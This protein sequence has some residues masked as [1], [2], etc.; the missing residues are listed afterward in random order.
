MIH[1]RV[2]QG[3]AEGKH[4]YQIH[5]GFQWLQCTLAEIMHTQ[6]CRI[7]FGA[8]KTENALHSDFL[9]VIIIISKIS[10]SCHQT[11]QRIKQL[12]VFFFRLMTHYFSRQTLP[13][14]YVQ[15]CVPTLVRFLY[16]LDVT[17]PLFG[18]SFTIVVVFFYYWLQ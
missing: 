10:L 11:S 5:L 17:L 16:V 13:E 14:V 3:T 12:P 9:A 2:L 15:F 4:C 6:C 18:T 1:F 8:C 7:S